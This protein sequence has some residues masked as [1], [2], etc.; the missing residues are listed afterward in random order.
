MPSGKLILS[1]GLPGQGQGHETVFAQ[2]AADVLGCPIEDVRV[3]SG[4]QAGQDDGIGTFG[5]RALVM[6]GNAVA[7]AA[8]GIRDQISS[9]AAEPIRVP[10][11]RC[12]DR[13][14]LGARRWLAICPSPPWHDRRASEPIR[15]CPTVRRLR[16]S[17]DPRTGSRACRLFIALRARRI[18]V[19]A[20]HTQDAMAFASGV[21]AAVV[22]VDQG[23][24][25]VRILRY[26]LV[27]DCG[28]IVNPVIVEGQVIGGLAQG[29]GGALLERLDFDP[30]GQPQ[31][32]SFMDF[33]MPT[34][35]D[36]PEVLLDHTVSPSPL[37]E[38]GVKGTGEAGV[39]PGLSRD[40][41]GRRGRAP[42]VRCPDPGRCPC[43]PTRSWHSSKRAGATAA[44]RPSA[45]G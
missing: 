16:R 19:Q 17:C 5:S 22:E 37:N 41:G 4:N 32:T 10:S 9:F 31:T 13:G 39:I 44:P 27:H 1:L 2:I 30:S 45:D 15:L 7:L 12:R 23:T 34:V 26:A 29:I 14:R 20:H 11:S 35:D 28:V 21:H 24:G 18:E 40:R 6:G 33:R 36:I 3:L 8:R 25:G 42:T 38:L 43:S